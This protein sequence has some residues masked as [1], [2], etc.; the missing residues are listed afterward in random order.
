[1][2]VF[3]CV[4]SVG[5]REALLQPASQPTTKSIH[6]TIFAFILSV[7]YISYSGRRSPDNTKN[8]LSSSPFRGGIFSLVEEGR[9][10][11]VRRNYLQSLALF[12]LSL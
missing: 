10:V 4:H 5:R 8:V 6:I 11:V 1:M 9:F 7:V 3:L 12:L 2:N